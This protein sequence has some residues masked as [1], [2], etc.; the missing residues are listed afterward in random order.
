MKIYILGSG[1]KSCKQ[2]EKN[3]IIALEEL[4]LTATIEEI[5]DFVEIAK[6]GVMQTPAIVVNDKVLSA[7]KTLSIKELKSLLNNL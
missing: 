3:T 5:T 1:C 2:L 6:Y 7:G 4:N